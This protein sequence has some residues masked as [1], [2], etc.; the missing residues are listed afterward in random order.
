MEEETQA[1]QLWILGLPCS[2]P[3]S[4]VSTCQPAGIIAAMRSIRARALE[5]RPGQECSRRCEPAIKSTRKG[6]CSVRWMALSPLS[7]DM[8]AQRAGTAAVPGTGLRA[9]GCL[10]TD[11]P[12]DAG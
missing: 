12:G 11:F 10:G 3:M 9:G 8:Q 5:S 2:L 4:S 1:L 7:F 6:R